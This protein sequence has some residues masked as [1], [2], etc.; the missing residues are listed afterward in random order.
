MYYRW[1]RVEASRRTQTLKKARH[2]I[3]R[4]NSELIR[5][6]PRFLRQHLLHI[7][8]FYLLL[9]LATLAASFSACRMEANFI[10]FP[11]ATIEQTPRRVGLDF[12][13]VFFS[14]R[15]DVRLNGWF[16]PHREARST[17]IWFHG[18]A[19]NISHRVENIKLLH[20][21][22]KIN[23]FI[24][25]YRG[26]GR[27]EGRVSEEGTYL[28]G[29]AAL[30]FV[31]K[32]LGAEPKKIILFGRSL[33]AAVAAEMANRFES[34]GLIL[35]TPFVS[36]REMAR[37][38]FPFLPLGL[39]LHTRYDVREKIQK[40]K[41][42]LLVLHGDQDEVVP[43][44]QGKMVFDAAPE[45]KKFFTIAGARH[46]DTYLVGGEPYF[47]QLQTFIDWASSIQR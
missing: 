26:Y 30:D 21:K 31:Q 16:I 12:E 14:T 9:S 33:G 5:A 15:D 25:D 28:D 17:L 10:F 2:I 22:V 23:I 11:S 4:T 7:R 37:V 38:V 35:E 43:F 45:P 19:G 18:N 1:T 8:H 36:I 39:L 40:I 32:R 46:N 44:T 47:Q 27:S 3:H 29:E 34:Q 41:T 42:P 6:Q 20:D 24:F 13:D